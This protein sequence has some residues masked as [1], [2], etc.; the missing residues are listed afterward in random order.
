VVGNGCDN[1]QVGP[2]AYSKD[3]GGRVVS[4]PELLEAFGDAYHDAAA[5]GAS[6][7]SKTARKLKV[8]MYSKK[9][10]QMLDG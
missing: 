8:R 2:A 10:W 6:T 7:T 3:R 4:H 5:F 9:L 1:T